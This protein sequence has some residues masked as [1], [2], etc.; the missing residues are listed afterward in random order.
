MRDVEL[1]LLS[2]KEIV[3]VVSS[4]DVV[5]EILDIR[6]PESLRNRFLENTALRNRKRLIL[7][8]NKR[9]LVPRDVAREWVEY[10]RSI[11]LEAYAVSILMGGLRSFEKILREYEGRGKIY[12]SVFGAPKV[13]KS[14]LINYFKKKRSA[15]V[16]KYPGTPGYTR[17]VQLYKISPDIYFIDTPGVLSIE[18]DSLERMIRTAPPEKLSNPVKI[19]LELIRRIQANTPG[20]LEKS[21]GVSSEDPEEILREYALKRRWFYETDKE[22]NIE[23]ASRDI[24]RRYLDGR[25]IYYTRPP[26][27]DVKKIFGEEK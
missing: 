26:K 15:S 3:E 13:G 21:L 7:L 19:A 8:L 2:K 25:I 11:G 12:F 20:S 22:P 9:D 1:R 5:V 24:I 17:H 6:V 10:Y 4:S 18:Y 27:R 14:S 23:E 16:S